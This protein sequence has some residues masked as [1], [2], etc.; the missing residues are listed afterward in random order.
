L[1]ENDVED[2]MEHEAVQD[3]LMGED[4]ELYFLSE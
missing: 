4:Y 1:D 3:E 2:G